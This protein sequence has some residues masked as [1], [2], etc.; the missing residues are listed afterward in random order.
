MEENSFVG[1]VRANSLAEAL[2]DGVDR[3]FSDELLIFACLAGCAGAAAPLAGLF[4]TGS[5]NAGS[6]RVFF[7]PAA[8]GADRIG[9]GAVALKSGGDAVWI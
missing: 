4:D 5:S 3:E 2:D 1:G 9:E 8:A 6:A 7:L